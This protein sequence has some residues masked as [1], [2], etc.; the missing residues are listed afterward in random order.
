MSDAVRVE[1]VGPGERD[2][3]CDAA[4]EEGDTLGYEPDAAPPRAQDVCERQAVDAQCT[5][6]G[7]AQPQEEI[8]EGG[9]ARAGG[10]DDAERAS[11]R[12]VEVIPR[13]TS[14]EEAG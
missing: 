9:F 3:L 2:V 1:V 14:S 11:E 13:R 5:V 10:P 6:R 7:C 4:V 12:D 8:D